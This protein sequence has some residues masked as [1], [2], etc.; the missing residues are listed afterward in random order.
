MECCG[1]HASTGVDL[2]IVHVMHCNVREGVR[3]RDGMDAVA[4]GRDDA[5]AARPP[6]RV[7]RC[8]MRVR[9]SSALLTSGTKERRQ[10][11]NQ[12][13]TSRSKGKEP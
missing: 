2:H 12:Y 10:C 5:Q 13:D 8:K 9:S 6:P 7:S 11:G 1:V 4:S 3:S